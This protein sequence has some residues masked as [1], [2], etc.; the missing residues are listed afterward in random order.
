MTA[1][2]DVPQPDPSSLLAGV[3]T[4]VQACQV[5][6]AKLV[7]LVS[8]LTDTDVRA[9]STLPDWSVGHVLTHLARN[10][11]SVVHLTR[12]VAQSEVADQYPG[13]PAQRTGD[14]EAGA[15]RGAAEQLADLRAVNDEIHAAW[16]AVSD[17]QWLAGSI[18]TASGREMPATYLPAMRWREVVVH[19]SDLGLAAATWREWPNDFVAAELP[20]LLELLVDRLDADGSRALVAQLMGRRHEAL[21]LPSVMW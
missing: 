21:E 15:G 14:I 19:T 10:G 1:A 7:Q 5:A 8:T 17:E 11:D 2:R 20:G 9:P 12:A 16:D 13:G 6:H 3:R 18:R 4:Q